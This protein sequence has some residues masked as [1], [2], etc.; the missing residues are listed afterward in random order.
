MQE[1]NCGT[2]PAARPL[3]GSE[4][5]ED[6][7]CGGL[8]QGTDRALDSP[9][10]AEAV[11][12]PLRLLPRLPSPVKTGPTSR[13]Q[14][15]GAG[16][17]SLASRR[18][19]AWGVVRRGRGLDGRGQEGRG[20]TQA[21]GGRAHWEWQTHPLQRRASKCAELPTSPKQGGSVQPLN[22]LGASR[23][24]GQQQTAP[25]GAWARGAVLAGTLS[26][27]SPVR[28]PDGSL[29][30][31]STEKVLG[32]PRAR[33]GAGGRPRALVP[34]PG[35]AGGLRPGGAAVVRSE[36]RC[37]GRRLQADHWGGSPR[38]ALPSPRS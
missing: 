31:P 25:A 29:T 14:A 23:S 37:T 8:S 21:Y 2:A 5:E 28:S 4:L 30:Q 9:C 36:R 7:L 32:P 34:G 20:R 22:K 3:S 15:W 19:V 17:R 26:K 35:A 1:Q 12:S 18:G 33:E 13:G 24:Q 27:D 11:Y 38:A 16:G 10:R 6:F